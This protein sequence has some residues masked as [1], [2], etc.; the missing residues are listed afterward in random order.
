VNPMITDTR[1]TFD[2]VAVNRYRYGDRKGA[3]LNADLARIQIPRSASYLR[4]DFW[5]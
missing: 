4:P 5:K 2:Q 3:I 1:T